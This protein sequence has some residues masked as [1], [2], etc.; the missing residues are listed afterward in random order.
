MILTIILI[1]LL[2]IFFLVIF[3]ISNS[4]KRAVF[5]TTSLISLAIIILG[6]FVFVDAAEF[7]ENFPTSEN[8][9]MLEEDNSLAAGFYMQFSAGSQPSLITEDK[10]LIQNQYFKENNL[11]AIKGE[12]YKLFIINKQA[13]DTV[14]KIPFGEKT[15]TRQQTFDIINSEN[16]IDDFLDIYFT[17]IP[18]DQKSLV[19]EQFLTGIKIKDDTEFKAMLFALLV[20][21]AMEEKGPLLIFEEYK[22]NNIQIYPETTLF[23]FIKKVPQSL[24][25]K[26]VK[27]AG[28]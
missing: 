16:A 11:E 10:L 18:F 21:S 7:K 8:L 1:I 24:L 2:I 9:L 5:F 17:D 26:V 27:L 25:E 12:S 4:I 19:K 13:L 14:D 23:K 22:E 28:E 3:K 6:I 15:F 20:S